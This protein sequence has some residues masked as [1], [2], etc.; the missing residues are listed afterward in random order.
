MDIKDI[1]PNDEIMVKTAYAQL[2]GK[3]FDVG[4]FADSESEDGVKHYFSIVVADTKK[5]TFTEDEVTEI[6]KP[7]CFDLNKLIEINHKY[8][9]KDNKLD[10][11]KNVFDWLKEYSKIWNNLEDAER[12]I[13]VEGLFTFLQKDDIDLF[14]FDVNYLYE[15]IEYHLDRKQKVMD[16]LTKLTNKICN[17]VEQTA[18]EVTMIA[19]LE[20][21]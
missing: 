6:I 11:T 20:G 19:N 12:N 3:V 17:A 14:L 15:M 5:I 7:I 13:I 8:F 10:D 9:E 4:A 16:S 18:N 2:H 1:K 21:E